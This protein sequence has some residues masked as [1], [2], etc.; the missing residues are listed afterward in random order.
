[1]MIALFPNESKNSSLKIATE[2]CQFLAEKGV[3]VVAEDRHTQ[4]IGAD[5][6]SQVNQDQIN[7]RISLGGDGTILRLVHRH[8][9]LQAPLLGIN[10]GSLGFLADIP[11]HDIYPSLQDLLN[12]HYHVQKRMVMEG[13]TTTGSNCFAVNEVVIHRAQNPCLIDLAVYVDE[14][15]LNTFSADGLII[16]TPS[17][18]TAY[19]LAAGGPIL[20]P[21]LNAFVL[22]P[23]CPHT[24]SNRPIVLMPKKSLQVRYLSALPPVEVSAD[25]IAS[26][27]L[28]TDEVFTAHLSNQTFNLVSLSRHDYFSTLREKLG[29]QGRLKT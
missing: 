23:I 19:S 29:W 9:T 26:F 5:P 17:G 8:P 7:F 21:E 10:L 14:R 11:L 27:S 18:S 1:M 4:T 22:T 25:G 13:I 28:S 20:T 16:S 6:L 15:Y 2:I 12:G 24:I 3:R